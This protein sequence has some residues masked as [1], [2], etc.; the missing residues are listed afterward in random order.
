MKKS[1]YILIV[2]ILLSFTINAQNIVDNNTD[3]IKNYFQ[4]K[5][6]ETN[7]TLNFDELIF[8]NISAITIFQK[9]NQNNAIITTSGNKKQA[10]NQIGNNNN[11]EF[12]AFYN[13]NESVIKINQNGNNN[14]VQIHGQNSIVNKLQITQNANNQAIIIKN[15]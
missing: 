2:T 7:K 6:D 13:A 4:Q 9:G 15:Y 11:Y 8:E 14:D 5:E 10:L 1:H 3:L 12:Y